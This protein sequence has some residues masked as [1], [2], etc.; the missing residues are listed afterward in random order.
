MQLRRTKKQWRQYDT[1]A[2]GT[3][4]D[5]AIK[6][7]LRD[8]KADILELHRRVALMYASLIEIGEHHEKLRKLW[9][10]ECN[11][12]SDHVR[13]H[14]ERSDFVKSAIAAALPETAQCQS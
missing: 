2:V 14:K 7:H 3:L 13:Y 12:D 1:N 4:S 6:R 11:A 8:A 10:E 5:D 9:T